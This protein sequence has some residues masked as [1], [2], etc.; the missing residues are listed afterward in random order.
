MCLLRPLLKHDVN[1]AQDAVNLP[2]HHVI[3]KAHNF[4][5]LLVQK[6]S[7]LGIA[8]LL[9]RLIVAAAI[10]LDRE[11]TRGAVKIQNV[12]LYRML[13]TELVL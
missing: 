7:P 11:T 5:T 2:Q 12:W 3:P 6:L 4:D 9:C 10:K 8:S 13:P 1:R